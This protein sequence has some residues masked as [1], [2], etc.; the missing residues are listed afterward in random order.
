M[1]LCLEVRDILFLR[2]LPAVSLPCTSEETLD[3]GFWAGLEL[4]T[5]GTSGDGPHPFPA[6]F[7]LLASRT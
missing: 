1:S 4:L 2:E 3:L 7:R 6:L 5:L